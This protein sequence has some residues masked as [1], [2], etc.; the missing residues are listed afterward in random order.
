MLDLIMSIQFLKHIINA[1]YMITFYL[2]YVDG[3]G[4]EGVG[5]QA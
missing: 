2:D 4:G 3:S 1:L 5:G